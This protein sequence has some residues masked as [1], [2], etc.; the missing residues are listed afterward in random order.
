MS[1]LVRLPNS[2][3]PN[4]WIEFDLL[5]RATK[6]LKRFFKNRN[7]TAGAARQYITLSVSSEKINALKETGES[8][9]CSVYVGLSMTFSICLSS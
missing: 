2:V 8:V 1:D 4:T 9:L 3:E 6:Q 7:R 5:C